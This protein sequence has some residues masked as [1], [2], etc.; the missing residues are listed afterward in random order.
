MTGM[1]TQH[2]TEIINKALS[3]NEMRLLE[4]EEFTR[5]KYQTNQEKT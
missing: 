3:S 4:K 1:R 5:K 2:N